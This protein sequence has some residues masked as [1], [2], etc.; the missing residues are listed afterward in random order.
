MEITIEDKWRLIL[1]SIA[2]RDLPLKKDQEFIQDIGSSRSYSLGDL[3]KCLEYVYDTTEDLVSNNKKKKK[4]QQ[5]KNSWGNK[6]IVT[7]TAINWLNTAKKLF[8]ENIYEIIQQDALSRGRLLALLQD[9]D[10]VAQI[11]PN[12]GLLATILTM[13]EQLQGKALDNAQLLVQSLVNKLKEHFMLQAQHAFY[14]KRDLHASPL[15]SFKNLDIKR[16][17]KSN[18]KYYQAD[19]DYIIPQ[20]LYFMPKSVRAQQHDLFILVDQSSS[21]MDSY[22]YS[23]IVASVFAKLGCLNTSLVVYSSKVVD[24]SDDLDDVVQL[25][26]KAQLNGGTMTC[27]ALNYINPKI[28]RPDKTIV[29]LISDL[30]DADYV[31]M[32]RMIKEQL[33]QQVKFIVLPSLSDTAPSYNQ[34]GAQE[35]TTLGA[36]VALLSPDKLIDYLAQVA[37]SL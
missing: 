18:I 35:L 29:V 3:D 36:H 33:A 9:D 31:S 8:P 15:K 13:K 24:Y 16:I 4:L 23:A 10:F 19:G 1:G 17:I 7:L 26:F 30:F 14:G 28:S 12:I 37:H 2:Q 20:N 25:L 34:R 6:D 5:N 32:V 21:M 22:A 11:Q 27:K